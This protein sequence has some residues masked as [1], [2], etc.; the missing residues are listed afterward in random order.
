[1]RGLEQLMQW[2]TRPQTV[3]RSGRQLKK[4]F[5]NRETNQGTSDSIANA[6][7][8]MAPSTAPIERRYG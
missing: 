1:M 8:I 5:T 3:R 4:A 7:L 2:T 6:G